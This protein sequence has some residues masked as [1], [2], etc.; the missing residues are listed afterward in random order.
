MTN[1]VLCTPEEEEAPGSS[2]GFSGVLLRNSYSLS[3][4]GGSLIL[5]TESASS[6]LAPREASE[7]MAAAAAAPNAPV[8]APAKGLA[9]IESSKLGLVAAE[10]V[11][12]EEKEASACSAVTSVHWMG[13]ENWV[14]GRTRERERQ[15][16]CVC[17]R[18]DK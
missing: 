8:A 18:E 15:K 13:M 7:L 6:G 2:T 5:N 17:Y 9:G 14:S 3:V 1:A 12:E 16:S 10:E 11:E 4:L